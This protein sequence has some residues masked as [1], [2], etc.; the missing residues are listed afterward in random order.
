MNAAQREFLA[1]HSAE[2]VQEIA[3]PMVRL[4]YTEIDGKPDPVEVKEGQTEAQRQYLASYD[5][6]S[7]E[8]LEPF[9]RSIYDAFGKPKAETAT[10]DDATG[11]VKSS[12]PSLDVRKIAVANLSPVRRGEILEWFGVVEENHRL[13][14]RGVP[15]HQRE[16]RFEIERA[17]QHCGP[18]LA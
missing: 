10:R 14:M 16:T 3:D 1:S 6:E 8:Q 11:A 17:M 2:S 5:V 18:Y 13:A 7:P 4:L 15:S 9:A 12:A